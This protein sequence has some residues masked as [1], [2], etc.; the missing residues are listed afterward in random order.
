MSASEAKAICREIISYDTEIK[1]MKSR[2]DHLEAIKKKRFENL[3]EWF[4][5]TGEEEVKCDGR[6]FKRVKKG[7][8]VSRVS[9]KQKQLAMN[10]VLKREG[11]R[12]V[13]RVWDTYKQSIKPERADIYSVELVKDKKLK[14]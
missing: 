1:S 11:L 7:K 12:D 8:I 3:Q 6:T 4:E 14:S 10:E 9:D 13:Q 2:K 5:T